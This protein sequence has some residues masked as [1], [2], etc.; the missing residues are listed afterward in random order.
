MQNIVN[1]QISDIDQSIINYGDMTD[2]I[3]DADIYQSMTP[4]PVAEEVQ[5]EPVSE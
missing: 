3:Q 1:S 5:I 4:E 2:V